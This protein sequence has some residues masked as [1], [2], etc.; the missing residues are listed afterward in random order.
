MARRDRR[1]LGGAARLAR[2]RDAGAVRFRRR[3]H[4]LGVGEE[5]RRCRQLRGARRAGERL[6]HPLSAPPR[7]GVRALRRGAERLRA[8]EGDER[9]RDVARGRPRLARHPAGGGSWRVAPLRRDRRRDPL[10]GVHGDPRDRDALLPGR[11]GVRLDVPAG[12]RA[13]LRQQDRGARRRARRGRRHPLAG[14]RV[15]RSG[16][17][18]AVPARAVA[19]RRRGASPLCAAPRWHHRARRT[20][21]RRAARARPVALGPP[22]RLQ[23]RRRGRLRRR[24]RAPLLALARRGADA[25]RRRRPG[26]RAR[27]AALAG[28]RASGPRAG[29]PG[30]DARADRD[31]HARRGGVRVAVRLRPRAGPLPLLPRAAPRRRAR[32]VGRARGAAAARPARHRRVRGGRARRRLPVRPLHRRAGEVGYVRPAAALDRERAPPG[33]VVLGDGARGGARPRG[34]ARARA[35]ATGDGGADRPARPL[36]RALAA[37]LVG[38]PRRA[39]LRGGRTV[40]GDPRRPA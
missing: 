18:G 40:P 7:A 8:G 16:R 37:G 32:G 25:L 26:C 14:N 34:V 10:D 3:A 4:L 6:Q 27:R 11:A 28:A 35:G 36:R 30:R 2:P 39:P 20:R 21:R 12:A 23:R 31:V 15:R 5:R 1:R 17:P 33:R 22:R 9:R 38:P 29:A 24:E 19:T 13:S